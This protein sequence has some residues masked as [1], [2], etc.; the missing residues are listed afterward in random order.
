MPGRLRKRNRLTAKEGASRIV[1]F[2]TLNQSSFD[3][4]SFQKEA[5]D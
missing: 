2:H 1:A 5:I 3:S 4:L